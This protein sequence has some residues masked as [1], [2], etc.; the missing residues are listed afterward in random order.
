MAQD[1]EDLVL[2]ISA[3]TRQMKR[4]LDR[5]IGDTAK[6]TG[7]I[8]KQFD[9]VGNVG[10]NAFNK[11]AANSNKAAA[12]QAK[13]GQAMKQSSIQT[14]N[15]A[16]QINDIGVQLAGGQS[17]FLIAL[18]QGSQINQ[19]LGQGGAR[20]AV[21]AL[22][23][24]FASLVN[25][26]SLAT[27]AIISLGGAA[28]QYFTEFLGSS[29]ESEKTLK[30][31]ADLIDKVAKKWGVATP[32]LKA[33]VD[34]LARAAD[35]KDLEDATKIIQIK[36]FDDL[37]G[38]IGDFR[39]QLAALQLQVDD[40]T[41]SP[42]QKAFENLDA[43]VKDGSASIADLKKLQF[44]LRAAFIDSGVPAAEDFAKAIG[45]IATRFEKMAEAAAKAGQE[46][47][48]A[49]KREDQSFFDPRDPRFN[50]GVLPGTAPTPNFRGVDDFPENSG[51]TAAAAFI[52]QFEGFI[53]KA[54]FDVNAFRVGFGSDTT[55][56]ATGN[57]SRVTKDTMTT[58]EDANRDL[59]RRIAEFQS[60]IE[61]QIG[62]DTFASFTD[63]QKAALTSIAYNYGELPDRI[64]NAIAAGNPEN[65]AKAIAGLGSDNGGI[66]KS[67]R[68]KEAQVFGGG[69]LSSS[70]KN[71]PDDL[72][73]GSIEDVQKRID[74]INAEIEA[75]GRLN[76]MVNDYGFAVD[77]ARIAQQLLNDAKKAGLEITPE[78]AAKI[79]QLATNYAK[80]SS[81]ADRL[82][83]SSQ[84]AAEATRAF[85]ELG[86]EILGGF[87][88]DLRSGKSA[89]E[90][91]GNALN[92]IADKL[93]DSGLN[94]LFG[95]LFGGGGIGRGGLL[96]GSIIPG[97]LHSGGI[98]GKDGY[99]HGRK[100]SP[101]VFAGA[102]RYH[103]GGI[104]G[105]RAGEVPAILQK[106][107]RIIPKGGYG[108]RDGGTG[109][110]VTLYVKGEEGPMFR[111]TIQAESQGVA[112]K[113]VQAGI[114][115]Y[116]KRLDK[117]LGGK[118][119]NAQA[120]TL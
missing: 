93:L 35:Q 66:N 120:R 40:T 28:I 49:L 39:A 24:A 86:K 98:A 103:Q 1:T 101:S 89:A 14:G 25:P 96:G 50:N 118:M 2:S 59:E 11:I 54:K 46:A 52:R 115:K 68:E 117:T 16:A 42:V 90:A 51:R 100:V 47:R 73:Q 84:N 80:A 27:I 6:T 23:G 70:T 109:G 64:V 76:P 65:I 4:A 56:D 78:L 33:Y 32:A 5:L 36:A 87:I 79:D 60:A 111:P 38:A 22:G 88:S 119:A 8:E 92:K 102:P 105:I 69:S 82:K 21:S 34:E 7:A 95:G 31:Q 110:T 10:T 97:I 44:E 3:D 45:N 71:T 63:E 13:F 114:T 72:F 106:G 99:G 43:K 108:G 26:V 58:L 48:N 18:Q 91:L 41:F 104:A 37:K 74:L 9:A 12:S 19:V 75:Q 67:R 30:E 113:V 17:P 57:I 77:K 53:S 20:A 85:G 81:S 83:E 112:V 55:T 29:A 61:G 107:E 116:D 94:A 62:A 15:L